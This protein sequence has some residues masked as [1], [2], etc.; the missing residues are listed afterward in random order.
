MTT[1]QNDIIDLH[2]HPSHDLLAKP[3]YHS[4]NASRN[5]LKDSLL[6]SMSDAKHESDDVKLHPDVGSV[7][8]PGGHIHIRY[9]LDMADFMFGTDIVI[10]R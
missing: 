4:V 2:K 7:P 3:L 6:R 10:I 1:K 8:L 9:S 5:Q